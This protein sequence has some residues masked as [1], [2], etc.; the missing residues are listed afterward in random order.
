MSSFV[1]WKPILFM[2]MDCLYQNEFLK[3][4]KFSVC[5]TINQ[6]DVQTQKFVAFSRSHN[7]NC[8][9]YN[10]YDKHAISLIKEYNVTLYIH[11]S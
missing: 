10:E 7:T 11:M 2:D 3:F 1:S 9:K 6:N 5:E 8:M 4:G